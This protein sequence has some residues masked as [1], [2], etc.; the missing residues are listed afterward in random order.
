M[1]EAGKILGILF[2]VL[3]VLNSF[4]ERI[5]SFA[6]GKN[7]PCLPSVPLVVRLLILYILYN[8]SYFFFFHFP[9][10]VNSIGVYSFRQTSLP[11]LRNALSTT[12]QLDI[13]FDIVK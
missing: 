4:S 1:I 2:S 3:E 9:I 12:S 5:P 11:K 10:H 7:Q 13:V 8:P 6:L